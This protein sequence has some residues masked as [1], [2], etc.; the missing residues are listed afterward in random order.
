[1][2]PILSA[3]FGV[4]S[5]ILQLLPCLNPQKQINILYGTIAD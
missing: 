4:I 3:N 5:I 1:M 2:D